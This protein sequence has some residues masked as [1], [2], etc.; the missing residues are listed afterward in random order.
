[1]EIHKTIKKGQNLAQRQIFGDTK[2]ILTPCLTMLCETHSKLIRVKVNTM[3]E[4][5]GKSIKLEVNRV[6]D[7][8]VTS[9]GIC[10]KHLLQKL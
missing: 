5:S 9:F 1:M 6:F 3:W 8:C 2:N 10:D 4:R 7:R